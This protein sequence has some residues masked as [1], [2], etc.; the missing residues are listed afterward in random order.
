MQLP[1]YLPQADYLRS[2][3]KAPS[4]PRIKSQHDFIQQCP[5]AKIHRQM[6]FGRLPR[7]CHIVCAATR[8][9]EPSVQ[10][11][12][13]SCCLFSG[14]RISPDPERKL[15]FGGLPEE[16]NTKV[17]PWSSHTPTPDCLVNFKI[18]HQICVTENHLSNDI[19]MPLDTFDCEMVKLPIF[20]P[21]TTQ[22]TEK[23]TPGCILYVTSECGTYNVQ[24]DDCGKIRDSCKAPR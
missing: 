8:L 14:Q 9:L 23:I 2:S 10:E 3:V 17:R 15:P 1:G 6:C 18:P 11:L 13:L 7:F 22:Q 4:F 24:Y 19:E 21:I 20:E 12:S 16:Q 5:D